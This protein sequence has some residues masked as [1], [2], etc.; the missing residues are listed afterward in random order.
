LISGVVAG[1]QLVPAAPLSDDPGAKRLREMIRQQRLALLGHEPGVRLGAAAGN[2]RKHRVAAR[3]TQAFLRSTRR[4]LD[5][6][7]RRTLTVPLSELGDVTGPVRD[8]DVLIEHV[9]SE[10][11]GLDP[12]DRAAGRSLVTRLELAR[13]PA[14]R[15]LLEALGGEEY[16][17]LLGRLR[18]PPRLAPGVE[19]IPLREIAHKEF[20]RLEK[21]VARLGE[22][23]DGTALHELRIALKRARYAA[24]LS[25]PVGKRAR[26]FFAHAKVL[27]DLL[28][29][30]QDAEIA[31]Q[32]LRATTVVDSPTEAAFIAGRLAERQRTRRANVT[33]QLPAAWKRLR[34][35]G[36][37]L[38]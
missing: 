8:L 16:R 36:A 12:Q 31:E 10:L 23:P 19:A 17:A 37:G 34:R 29:E 13:E 3:R 15:R 11:D 30:Y 20:T 21:M 32:L 14:R 25:A 18:L 26:R 28:G 1:K 33:A 35:S 4:Y 27:Q 7:W 2:L 24:E 9:Q 38:R 22:Q 5:P 6:D